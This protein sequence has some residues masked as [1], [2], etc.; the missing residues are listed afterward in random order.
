MSALSAALVLLA[1]LSNQGVI[2]EALY[3]FQHPT[4]TPEEGNHA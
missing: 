4:T 1:W 2:N 3:R